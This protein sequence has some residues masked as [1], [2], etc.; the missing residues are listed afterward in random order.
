M[1]SAFFRNLLAHRHPKQAAD[2]ETASQLLSAAVQR[3]RAGDLAGADETYD[4]IVRAD[5]G[6]ADAIH[7]RGV[8]ALQREDFD[9]AHALI[10][11][12][13]ALSPGNPMYLSHLSDVLRRSGK[14]DEAAAVLE[15]ANGATPGLAM[16]WNN[17]GAVYVDLGLAARGADCYRAALR[18]QPENLNARSGLLFALNLVPG[19]APGEMYAEYLRW[20]EMHADPILPANPAF[21]RRGIDAQRLRIG[22]VS[23]DFRRHAIAPFILPVLERHD[24]ARFDVFAYSSVARPDDFT[25]QMRASTDH[26][27]DVRELSDEALAD[28]VRADGIDVLVDMSGHTNGNR[29]GAFARK[30]APLQV[31]WLG[32]TFSTGMA[33]MDGRITDRVA[34]DERTSGRY[35]RERLYFLPHSLWCFRP[36]PSMPE[37]SA[38]PALVTG[39]LTFVSMN[40][41]AKLNDAVLEAWA[42]ILLRV[43]QSRLRLMPVQEGAVRPHLLQRLAHFGVDPGRVVFHGRM[44]QEEFWRTAQESDI[45]L[46]SFPC[47]G[48]ATTCEALWLG[49]PVVATIGGHFASRISYSILKAGGMP[50]LAAESIDGYVELACTLAANPGA[51]AQLRGGL[52]MRLRKSA[53]MDEPQYVRAFEACLLEAWH[54]FG[55]HWRD[56]IATR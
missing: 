10:E 3:H 32:S 18:I 14:L 36:W 48:G 38:L 54:E 41:P 30:P 51:L 47:N 43:P 34:D 19:I 17:V 33:A 44:G 52:R 40:N 55:P 11:R 42:R 7:L 26:W 50:E 1:L 56:D 37:V 24:R 25:A 28:T 6:N 9:A 31:T 4:R 5:P 23:A 8:I 46:D 49:L 45:A 13:L 15:T 21:A 20:A 29:L 39:R 2:P 27:H 53:L 16:A 22:Y 35:N 12:A